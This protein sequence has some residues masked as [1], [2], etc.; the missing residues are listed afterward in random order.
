LTVL[1]APTALL[2]NAETQ[3][4]QRRREKLE[5]RAM[6]VAMRLELRGSEFPRREPGNQKDDRKIADR[7]MKDRKMSGGI[8]AKPGIGKDS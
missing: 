2:F 5:E 6:V 1:A 3:R 8:M 7:K 4:A